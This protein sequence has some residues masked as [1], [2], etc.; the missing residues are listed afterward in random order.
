MKTFNSG[1]Y[2]QQFKYKSFSPSFLPKNLIIEDPALN[3]LVAE[4]SRHLGELNALS[5]MVPNVDLFIHMHVMKEA[6]QSSRI[7]G[8]Q[9]GFDEALMEEE[10]IL[11]EK[12]DDWRE[13]QNYTLAMNH[14][15]A[16][17]NELPLSMRL[18][19]ET[20]KTLMTAARGESKLPGEVRSSQNWIGGSSLTDAFF[21]PPHKD[22]L[23]NLLSNLE[24]FWHDENIV[25]A[26]LI[27]AALSHY[28][29]ET[30]HPFLDGNG[31]IGRLL[32]TLYLLDKKIL[33]YPVLYLSDFFERNKG[34]YYDSLT[35]VRSSHDIGQWLRFFM[36]GVIETSQKGK[37]TFEKILSL[38]A[39]TDQ[40]GT[41]LGK[42]S[43][44]LFQYLYRHPVTNVNSV[45]SNLNMSIPGANNLI[46]RFT[47][48]KYL[49]EWTGHKRNR[50]FTFEPYLKIFV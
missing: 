26:P 18:V 3:L 6:T 46:E 16:R 29:F 37:T 13:I 45:A 10:Q 34:S 27:K 9:T 40:E 41:R 19:K 17:L 31:R 28:Q 21:I 39:K 30:I 25:L 20:H 36:T 15:I 50:S 43:P 44:E 32:I 7:E 14:A 12:R 42:K 1:S 24:D 38:K 23:S 5:Q 22:E 2:K 4:A 48:E 8:T 35:V 47:N 49:V 33:K 11:P